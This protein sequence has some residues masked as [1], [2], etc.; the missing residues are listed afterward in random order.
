MRP[1]G[2]GGKLSL[3]STERAVALL[4]SES[5]EP[6]YQSCFAPSISR[7]AINA[8]DVN[9]IHL[10]LFSQE[11]RLYECLWKKKQTKPEGD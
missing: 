10:V 1:L 4:L 2:Q 9:S 5:I 6:V 8:L 11:K 7:I 3:V